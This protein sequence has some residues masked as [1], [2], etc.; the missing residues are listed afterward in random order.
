MI[1]YKRYF[2]P[3]FLSP[4]SREGE[5]FKGLNERS[6]FWANSVRTGLL[7]VYERLGVGKGDI[8]LLPAFSP[9]GLFLPA[10]RK[11]LVIDYYRLN[12][13][14]GPDVNDIAKRILA[15]NNIKVIFVIHFFGFKQN[16]DQLVQLAHQNG[17]IVIE[18]CA[19]TLKYDFTYG[20]KKSEIKGD[21]EI[22]SLSKIL[23]VP[24]GSLFIINN[25]KLDFSF[26]VYQQSFFNLLSVF[27]NYMQLRLRTNEY[28]SGN[29]LTRS[30]YSLLCA[31]FHSLYYLSLC[32]VK[33]ICGIS[34]VSMKILRRLKLE[35][36]IN[37]R[38]T[39]AYCVVYGLKSGGI[40][41]IIQYENE[42][43]I[44]GVPFISPKRDE[45]VRRLKDAG[46]RTLSY[47]KLWWFVPDI[48]TMDFEA[49]KRVHDLHFLV[50]V[51]ENVTVEETELL[52]NELLK[53]SGDE[54][55]G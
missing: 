49:E 8:I 24:D 14:M 40:L 37:I 52:I 29:L 33:K 32:R 36:I 12:N 10:R 39:N 20:E 3:L 54:Y 50:P 45:I 17:I 26:I 27:S 11:G 47:N 18:D 55:S 4:E 41:P 44:T 48:R 38:K 34:N 9:H 42:S 19:H 6:H 35:E 16:I 13:E 23:P 15:C 25:N 5:I 31:A 53:I 22:Y 1:T 43:I 51:N 21:I 28:K 7:A 46:I 2:N 30:I